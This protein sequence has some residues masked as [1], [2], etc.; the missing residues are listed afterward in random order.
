MHSN[1]TTGSSASRR[2]ASNSKCSTAF[3]HDI[4]NDL[5]VIRICGERLGEDVAD[6]HSNDM[7]NLVETSEH[8]RELTRNSKE[9]MRA[10]TGESDP[11]TEP[12]RIGRLLCDELQKARS[13]YS[14]ASL[15]V[16]AGLPAATEAE[17]QA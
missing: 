8:I 14:G 11:D 17:S 4:Q 1:G 12:V 9:Y 16:A 10:V 2:P 13:T 7:R 5:G 6:E 3:K 15:D